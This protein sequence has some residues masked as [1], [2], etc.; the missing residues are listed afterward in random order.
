MSSRDWRLRIQDILAAIEAIQT[1]TVSMALEDFERNETV[2]KAVLYDFIIIGE[3]SDNVP[4]EVQQR[5]SELPWR[6]MKDMWNIA[7][8]EYF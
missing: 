1:Q 3:A 7:A 2:I 6:L 5:H 4:E 8:H